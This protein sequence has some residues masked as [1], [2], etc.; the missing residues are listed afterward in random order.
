MKNARSFARLLASATA[1]PKDEILKLI[2]TPPEKELGNLAF[3]CF[4]VAKEAGK[5]PAAVASH[6]AEKINADK[7]AWLA[8]A[9]AAGPYVNVYFN[10]AEFAYSTLH[11]VI[12]NPDYGSDDRGWGKTVLLDYSSPNIAK[13]FHVGHLGSTIIGKALDNIYRF[14][15]Y[16]VTSINHLGDWGTQFGKLITAYKAWG[17][18]EN[19]T[20]DELVALYVRFHEEAEKDATLGDTARAWVVKMQD[21]DEEG[22]AIWQKFVDLSLSEYS[23][24]YDRLNVNFDLIRGESYYRD[25]LDGTVALLREKGLLVESEGAQIVD[26][27]EH[28]MPPCLILRS[29]GGTLYPTRDL[30]AAIDRYNTFHF[31][32]CLYVTDN[33]QEL[34]FRQWFKVLEMLGFPWAKDLVH[35]TYG[36]LLFEGGKLSTR[37]GDV[38]KMEDLLDEAVAKTL[39]IIEEKN[40]GLWN[41]QAVAEQV[42]IGAVIFNKLYTSRGK[43]TKFDWDRMLNFDGETGPYVQY[44]HAR[45]CSVLRKAL[46]E[47]SRM[48]FSEMARGLISGFTF[49]A[50]LLA[51]DEAFEVLLQ[52]SR[53]PAAVAEAE[54]KYEPFV[55][56]RLLVSLAQAFNA[57]YH[58]HTILT[59]DEPLRRARL[60]LAAAVRQV[61][62]QGLE[63]LGISAPAIM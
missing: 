9:K 35:V 11:D 45:T 38:I 26:L 25:M 23:V 59:D 57:F 52:L 62:K 56:A 29:D 1:L 2:E 32:K 16:D 22:L 63:L 17:E 7:P 6:L 5:A 34:Q 47:G 53:F 30:A 4:R 18:N 46:G 24:I 20:I 51:E 61:L 21:G 36:M 10:R 43:D 49:D 40:P 13:H 19:P 33:E 44:A 42:G 3:P 37:K 27:E 55:I 28:G 54:D 15:G 12:D 31:D 60:A 14:Q 48:D 50:G 8:E 41:K 39:E 58:N